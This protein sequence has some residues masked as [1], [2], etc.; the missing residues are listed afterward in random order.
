M[1]QLIVRQPFCLVREKR[2][3]CTGSPENH[4]CTSISARTMMKCTG[5]RICVSVLARRMFVG[6][7]LILGHRG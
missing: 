3:I 4:V 5:L 2:L 1:R 6:M 7:S